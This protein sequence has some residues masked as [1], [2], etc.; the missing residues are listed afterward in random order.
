MQ[1]DATGQI[2]KRD[3]SAHAPTQARTHKVH[4]MISHYITDNDFLLKFLPRHGNNVTF[5]ETHIH[6]IEK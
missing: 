1:N 2:G 6:R 5:Y 4:F 3:K